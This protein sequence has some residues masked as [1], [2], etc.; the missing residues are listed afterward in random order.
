MAFHR[1]RST[2]GSM[3]ISSSRAK[4]IARSAARSA[5]RSVRNSG[6]S[7]KGKMLWVVGI[8]AVVAVAFWG[9]IKAMF[10]KK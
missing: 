10:H 2:R 3:G 7:K 6:K 4:Y 8:L 9:K 5:V 1:N